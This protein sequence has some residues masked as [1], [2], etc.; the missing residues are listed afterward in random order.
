M[1]QIHNTDQGSDEWFELRKGK[2]TASNATPIGANGKGLE[3]YCKKIV[4]EMVK[5][6]PTEHY[7]NSDIERGNE[8]ESIGLSSYEFEMNCEVE[9]VGFITNDEFKNV[10][11][12]PDGLVGL[13]G[14]IE[15]KAR[16]DDKHFSLIQG[17]TKE[18]PFNQIQMCLLVSGRKWWDFISINTNFSKSILIK[19]IYPDEKYFDKLKKG[20]E[21]G[22]NLI[23]EYLE[24]YNNYV[25]LKG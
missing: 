22:N 25:N 8:L 18:I 2:M 17:D 19:R 3:T 13:N 9:T 5:T 15:I 12:S 6:E 14:G 4:S 21:K 10:G 16:N 20:F 1:I 11:C 23:V 24:K 7:T